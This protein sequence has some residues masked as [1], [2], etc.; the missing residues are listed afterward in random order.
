MLYANAWYLS[1]CLASVNG[2]DVDG[3]V[4]GSIQWR[5]RMFRCRTWKCLFRY[6]PCFQRSFHRRAIPLRSCSQR[7]GLRIAPPPTY[8]DDAF[9]QSAH[10]FGSVIVRIGNVCHQFRVPHVRPCTMCCCAQWATFSPATTV[11]ETQ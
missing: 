1:E 10:T 5:P 9:M 4:L 6:K 7:S 3:L 2:D 11:D 8:S